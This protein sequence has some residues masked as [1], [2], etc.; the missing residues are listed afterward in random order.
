[1]MRVRTPSRDAPSRVIEDL[2]VRLIADVRE[3]A[4]TD[5]R[6][7]AACPVGVGA[8]GFVDADRR[9]VRFSPHV[10]WRDEP[11]SARLEARLGQP[12]RLEND[13]NAAAWAESA[14]GVGRGAAGFVLVTVGTGI[15][16]AIVRD[17]RLERGSN[18]MAGEFGHMSLVP[19][20]RR[21]ACG[22]DGCWEE[23][24]SGPA[25]HRYAVQAG[26]GRAGS[27]AEL[28]AADDD[29]ETLTGPM[30]GTRARAG[31]PNALLAVDRLGHWLGR[32]LANV[33][34]A[35]DPGV[36][37]IGGG[38]MALGELLL[39]PTRASLAEHCSGSAYRSMP[40]IKTAILGP[41]AGV[42]GAADLARADRTG[43]D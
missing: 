5:G 22:K 36:I 17:G 30:I 11:L 38:V 37:V 26:R 32:G 23:Y 39:V 34:V 42:I 16:G 8:A 18:G 14:F 28:A 24:A 21:C 13:A 2:L 33:V 27:G 20:G 4:N 6:E 31:D 10:N 7:T 25:L 9:T 41:L 3:A 15:G 1:M 12:V 35:L 43:P 29:A 40:V 19:G